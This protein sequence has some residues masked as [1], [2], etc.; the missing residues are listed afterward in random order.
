MFYFRTAG[1]TSAAR[2]GGRGCCPRALTAQFPTA[3]TCQLD[4]LPKVTSEE[5]QDSAVKLEDES[6]IQKETIA[7]YR[8]RALSQ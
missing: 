5:Q 1:G 6:R 2:E 8:I 7:S 4:G 3:D